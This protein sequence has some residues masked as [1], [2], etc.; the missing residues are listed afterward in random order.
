MTE[1]DV[2]TFYADYVKIIYSEIEARNNTLPIELLFEINSAFDH[3]KRYHVDNQ[4]ENTACEK[5]YSHLKRGLLDAYKIKLKYFNDDYSSVIK[6]RALPFIDNGEFLP[7]LIKL[8]KQIIDAG[9]CARLYESKKDIDSAFEYWDKTSD[10]INDF[11]TNYFLR[12]KLEWGNRQAFFDAINNFWCGLIA[13][14]VISA[15]FFFIDK[16]IK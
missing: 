3:L 2:Y 13:S 16:F 7:K 9:K 14:A 10:L 12:E 6:A 11:E 8:H 4:D 15:I 5:A 1:N